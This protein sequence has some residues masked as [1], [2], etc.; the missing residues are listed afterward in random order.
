MEK[1]IYEY[2]DQKNLKLLQERGIGFEDIIAI[3]DT[4]GYL[5]IIDHPNPTKYPHQKIYIVAIDGYAYLVPFE[6]R[7][8]KCVFKTI[9]PSRK[10]TRLYREKLLRGNL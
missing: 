8:N 6:R 5:A 1:P 3:L 2:N 4:K 10:I 7:G 9:Y